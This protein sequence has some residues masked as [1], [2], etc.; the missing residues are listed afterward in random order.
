MEELIKPKTYPKGSAW[1]TLSDDQIEE[2]F[3]IY[4]DKRNLHKFY[5]LM[6]KTRD[7]SELQHSKLKRE[8]KSLNNEIDK[9]NF[10]IFLNNI[11]NVYPEYFCKGYLLSQYTNAVQEIEGVWYISTDYFDFSSNEIALKAYQSQTGILN[12]LKINNQK[13]GYLN[14]NQ[15]SNIIEYIDNPPIEQPKR[16]IYTYL[17]SDASN[18][19]KIGKTNNLKNRFNTLRVGNP[20]LKVIAHLDKNI[21]NKL[22]TLFSNKRIIG[23]WFE[24]TNEELLNLIKNYEFK[25]ITE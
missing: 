10:I 2:L 17:M 13:T 20:T 16:I 6:N 18:Y 19:V 1:E 15:L 9:L 25:I 21:E 22:H 11:S 23:E 14:F 12:L 3:N 8:N 7:E 24:F 5:L 4:C